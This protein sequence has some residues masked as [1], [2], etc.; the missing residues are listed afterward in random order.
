MSLDAEKVSHFM[1][2]EFIFKFFAMQYSL[3]LLWGSMKKWDTL[4]MLEG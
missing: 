2:P 1:L 4:N 3:V